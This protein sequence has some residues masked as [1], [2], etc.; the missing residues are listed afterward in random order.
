[1]LVAL[2]GTSFFLFWALYQSLTYYVV[3]VLQRATDAL[4]Q[5]KQQG[6]QPNLLTYTTLIHGWASASYPEK[7]LACYDDMKATG[8]RPDKAL[9]HCIMTSLLSRAAVAR[10]LVFDGVV[11][12]TNE[13]VD[14]GIC[15]DLATAKHWQK[16]L[17]KAER[18]PGELVS[19]VRKIYPPGTCHPVLSHACCNFIP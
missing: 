5:M 19:T 13:M 12:V 2:S 4:E 14:Q 10:E 6:V 1:M 18:Q 8:L 9:Y 15:V 7:A 17:V 3:G 16:F 11:R